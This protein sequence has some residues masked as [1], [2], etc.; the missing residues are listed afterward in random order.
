MRPITLK[1]PNLQKGPSTS[2]EFNGLRN[3]IQTDLTSLFDIT[4]V[5]EKKIRENMDVLLHEQFFMQNRIEKLER[6]VKEL[7]WEQRAKDTGEESRMLRSFY[8][9][10]GLK[11]G[12][13]QKPVAIDVVRGLASPVA[14]KHQSKLSYQ[15]DTGAYI[16]PRS[17]EVSV[18]ETNDTQP[19]EE[20]TKERVYYTV[21]QSGLEKA[22]DGD[23]N[24]FWIR[25]SSFSATSGVTEVYGR[26][27]IKIPTDIL[28]NMYVNTILL[29]PYPEYSMTI[30]DIQYKG[31]GEQWNRIETYPVSKDAKGV[32]SPLPI[33][34]CGKILLSFPRREMTEITIL[35]KQPYWFEHENKRVFVYG[36]QDINLEYREYTTNPSEFVSTYSLEGT[37]K[38]F[39]TIQEP[40]VQLPIGCPQNV[41]GCIEHQLYYDADLT[42][43]FPFGHEISAPIQTVYI[44]TT[45]QK[46]G[47]TVPFIKG[48]ELPYTHKEID[49]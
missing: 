4:N 20:N 41:E 12:D 37:T 44:K 43:E 5:H 8:H 22:I 17:L 11:D 34:E 48:M 13:I 30:L 2:E 24:T 3:D 25:N 21:D 29:N 14:T 36:F 45:L 46:I 18:V 38:R 9:L 35:F 1:N 47:E 31:L 32:V 7:E 19:F 27:H 33:E 49:E 10:E 23:K 40:S 39:S 15:T 42:E 26:M 28:N 16:I 6:R